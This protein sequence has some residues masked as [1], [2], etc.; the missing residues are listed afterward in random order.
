MHAP[1]LR[2][3]LLRRSAARVMLAT[4]CVLL[5]TSLG[6][7]VPERAASIPPD[8]TED[9][10]RVNCPRT[11]FRLQATIKPIGL[12]LV[13]SEVVID[14]SS[15][16][17]VSVEID[18]E[19]LI[20]AIPRFTWTIPGRPAGSTVGLQ[21]STTLT[22]MLRPGRA[23][24]YRL[25]LTVCSPFCRLMVAGQ[26]RTV[27]TQTRDVEITVENEIVFPPDVDPTLPPLPSTNRTNF[28]DTERDR[29]CQGGGGF[30]DPQWVTVNR[31]Q[32]PADYRLLEGQVFGSRSSSKDNFQNHNS[33]DHITIVN[34]DPPYRRLVSTKAEFPNISLLGIE[35][36]RER[37]PER[38]RATPG[39]RVSLFG[40]WIFDCGHEPFYTEIHPPVGMAVHRSRPVQIPA[41]FRPPGFPSG[42]GANV[43]APGIVTDLWFNRNAGGATSCVNTALHQ[44]SQNGITD[45]G[46][47]RGPSSLNRVFRF[48]IY[49]PRDPQA[50]LA[51]IGRSAPAVPLYFAAQGSDGPAPQIVERSSG[52]I[53]WLEV[54]ID[55]R[56]FTGTTYGRRIFAAWA[57]PAPDNWHIRRWRLSLQKLEVSDDGDWDFIGKGDGDWRFWVNTN[58][59]APEWTK[60]FDCDGCVTGTKTFPAATRTGAGLGSD[61]LLFPSQLIWVSTSGYEEDN[62]VD[63]QMGTVADL[64][65]QVGAAGAHVSSS[66]CEGDCTE[67]RLF[68]RLEPLGAPVAAL[69]PEG[70]ALYDAYVIRSGTPCRP[71]LAFCVT[72]PESRAQ[73]NWHPRG[74]KMRLTR[75][76]KKVEFALFERQPQETFVLTDMTAPALR[77]LVERERKRQPV[78]VKRSVAQVRSEF[79]SVLR[80][81]GRPGEAPPVRRF[82]GRGLPPDLFKQALAL[83]GS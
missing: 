49:L 65:D 55:L 3:R 15:A 11:G 52:A 75:S 79:F 14:A 42:F 22:P 74:S 67:Y 58:N 71:F 33:Q 20:A 27:P 40:Y 18:C 81:R 24:V 29:K 61:L 82:F 83:R 19:V 41:N 9:G 54:S 4:V 73:V 1:S 63:T 26:T 72:L 31:F 47:I 16:K 66:S 30:V 80:S 44:P 2:L 25:R 70:R 45:A 53:R 8:R 32:S 37:L 39:D 13:G 6:L 7:G 34:P 76:S 51:E 59:G 23:G 36:E 35:W 21:G 28:P 48:N 68:Y 62:F 60:L 50:V 43:L 69:S 78:A 46:C 5:L 38:F 77:R 10:D 17:L 12:P 64:L 56:G 57:Y